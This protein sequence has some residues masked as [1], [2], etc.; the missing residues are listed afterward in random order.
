MESDTR[1]MEKMIADRNAEFAKNYKR[2]NVLDSF[3]LK[4]DTAFGI[5]SFPI[6]NQLQVVGEKYVVYMIGSIIVVK[7]LLDKS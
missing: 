5:N 7:D 4:L 6:C 1:N 2:T 3:S